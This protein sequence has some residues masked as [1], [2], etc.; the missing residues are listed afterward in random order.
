MGKTFWKQ[1]PDGS[2]VMIQV[3]DCGLRAGTIGSGPKTPIPLGCRDFEDLIVETPDGRYLFNKDYFDKE[4]DAML[5][6]GNLDESRREA[7]VQAAQ[8][9]RLEVMLFAGG[10][11]HPF[12]D[13][14]DGIRVAGGLESPWP[15]GPRIPLQLIIDGN[16]P[17]PAL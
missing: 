16:P 6:Q 13:T 12:D 7:I 15:G 2:Y 11:P 5:D 1:R 9:G 8:S 4:L 10:I 17:R 14:L 3:R